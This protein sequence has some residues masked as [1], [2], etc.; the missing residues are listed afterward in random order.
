MAV[1]RSVRR[2]PKP[3]PLRNTRL[4]IHPG[5]GIARVGNDPTSFFLGPE[6]PGQGPVGADAGVGTSVTSGAFS[7]FKTAADKIK[8][9]GQRFRI[10]LHFPDQLPV[11]VNLLDSR[12]KKIDWSVHL[13]NKKAAF[14]EFQGQAGNS[15]ATVYSPATRKRNSGRPAFGTHLAVPAEPRSRLVI[16][17]GKPQTISGVSQGPKNIDFRLGGNF[18]IHKLDGSVVIPSLGQLFTD[19][20]GRLV[21]LG[22]RGRSKP[23]RKDVDDASKNPPI[24]DYANNDGWLDD[25]SDGFVK[26]TVTMSDGSTFAA[27]S[28]WILVGPP[29]FAPDIGQVVSLYDTLWDVAARN[30]SI[31][32]PDLQMFKQ[33][34]LK[35]L[36]TF[37]TSPASYRP[38]YFADIEPFLTNAANVR[39]VFPGVGH[40]DVVSA[41]ASKRDNT[42]SIFAILRPPGGNKKFDFS[43][44]PPFP[45]RNMPLLY[46]DD[47]LVTTSDHQALS[48]TESQFLNIERWKNGAVDVLTPASGI[49]PENLDRAALQSCS[50]GAFFPG[51]E[52]GWM[53]RNPNIWA[54]PFRLKPI[55][56]VLNPAMTPPLKIEPGLFSQQMALPWQADFFDCKQGPAPDGGGTLYG[57]WPSQRPSVVTKAGASVEW[58]RGVAG[59]LG[60]IDKWRTRGF[61]VKSGGGNFSE[62]GGP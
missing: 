35:R 40:G 32:I 44:G 59:R 3:T 2:G 42:G 30:P 6:I 14:F 23:F 26:A 39:F 12:V 24:V 9:Q 52:S 20:A 48:V 13:A 54:E 46:G 43:S 17:P 5:I 8:R 62:Q 38:E 21:V 50:G 19:S 49:S 10:F 18:P 33:E 45:V 27:E 11:E 57:W 36:V 58:D 56:T 34:P 55:G 28:A 4:R 61:V 53:I 7:G 41:L 31:T 60:L 25:V 29:D 15:A 51:M 47:Y 16:D 1:R 37:R 22:G